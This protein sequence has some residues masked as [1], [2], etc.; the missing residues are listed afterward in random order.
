MT[1]LL[2]PI[3]DPAALTAGWVMAN[4]AV[5]VP[6]LIEKETLFALLKTS[7]PELID[8]VPAEN[9]WTMSVFWNWSVTLWMEFQSEGRTSCV[10]I[11]SSPIVSVFMCRMVAGILRFP[12]QT[13]AM[14]YLEM[15]FGP[16]LVTVRERGKRAEAAAVIEELMT[17]VGSD[18]AEV[19]LDPM[20]RP[21]VSGRGLLQTPST[22]EAPGATIWSMTPK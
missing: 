4:E 10:L 8:D 19:T 18:M 20:M 7:V 2:P 22:R 5:M 21:L 1:T 14:G 17:P 16:A 6:A 9:H 15:V 11:G 13:R 12:Q 3:D